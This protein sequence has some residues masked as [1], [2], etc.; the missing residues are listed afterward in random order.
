MSKVVVFNSITL[1][2]VMQAPARPDEDTR[3]GFKYGGWAVPYADPTFG[4]TVGQSMATTEGILLGRRTYQDFYAYWPHRKDNPFT[5]V[6]NN[7][8][9]Y[10][11]TRTLKEPLPWMNS[12]LL[13]GNVSKAVA[14]LKPQLQ[15][16]IVILGSGV[17]V[18]SLMKDNLIDKFILSIH[19]IVLGTG[20]RLFQDGDMATLN[21]IDSEITSKGVIIAT[22]ESVK[23]ASHGGA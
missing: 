5:D 1:D 3:G 8:P 12:T 20:K 4:K 15:K 10:V 22:Y 17:L 6:L 14:D 13:Q 7:A 11:A 23:S 19:P 21:L 9:K 18:Q 16:D 2:G